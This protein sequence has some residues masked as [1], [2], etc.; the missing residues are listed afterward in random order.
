MSMGNGAIRPA[1]ESYRDNLC[2][3][4][5]KDN[6]NDLI[7]EMLSPTLGYL[8]FQEQII[9]FLNRFCGFSMGEADVVRRG[10]SKK[11]GTEQ[12]IPKIESGFIKTMKKEHGLDEKE[13][14]QIIQSF[15][16]VIEDASS[17]L[18]SSNHSVPYSM[19]GYTCA[20]LRYYHKIEFVTTM[21]RIN[22]N[23]FDK[24]NE[25][26]NYA[27][28]NKINVLPPRFGKSRSDYFFDKDNNSI[29]RGTS[30][31]KFITDNI[32]DQLYELG[33][34]TYDTF[35]EFL[36]DAAEKGYISKKYES[37][38]MVQ[39]F[40]KFGNNKKLLAIFEEFIKGDNR[41]SSKHKDDTKQKRI[42]ALLEYEKSLPNDNMPIL[43]QL[44][45]DNNILGYINTCY[46]H[47]EKNYIFVMDIDT[48]FAPRVDAYCLANGK[49]D[50]LK[51]QKR[52][53][54]KKSFQ[55]GDIVY[56][57]HF[58]KKRPIKFIN[59]QYVDDEGGNWQWW[60]TDYD[61]VNPEVFNKKLIQS[62]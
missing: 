24:T 46:P 3:G 27:K 59:G 30:S 45:F 53:F 50:S 5:F 17:Y 9:E 8:V 6:G 51:I 18:F 16:R 34:N 47:I 10:F 7:N 36:V 32:S 60:I 15:L 1:G 13:S 49:K 12:Y 40:E 41:Y 29:Y 21:L 42:E 43:D 14:K 54:N 23:N 61:I 55:E 58:E 44:T 38:I 56:C 62:S 4:I 33:K 11:V 31:I 25:I 20:W 2:E 26:I 35:V 48:K 19:I 28:D 57:H 52:V 39:Y 37:L 22:K